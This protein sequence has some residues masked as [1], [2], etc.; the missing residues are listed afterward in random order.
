MSRAKVRPPAASLLPRVKV[1]YET[2]A[3]F[4]FGAGL[5]AILRAV[6]E[7]GSIKHA[8]ESLGRSY[9]HIW[10]RIKDV[11]KALGAS[12]VE[13]HVGGQGVQRSALTPAARRL[14]AEFQAIRARMIEVMEREFG[15]RVD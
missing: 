8:A 13:A 10:D 12:L 4:G 7:T 14:V 11:E 6:D 15:G 1:W 5:I 3:G 2:E 9:R